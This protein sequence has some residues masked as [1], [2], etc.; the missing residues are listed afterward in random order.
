[1]E[2]IKCRLLFGLVVV[3]GVSLSSCSKAKERDAP[4]ALNLD[5]ASH[6]EDQFGKGFGRDFRADPMSKPADVENSDVAP[7]S[8]TDQ[9][10]PIQ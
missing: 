1:M 10:V 4:A 5:S 3:A 2:L 7:V 6:Q 8:D 9:P